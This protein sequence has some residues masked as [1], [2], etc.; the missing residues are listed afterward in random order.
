MP[1]LQLPASVKATFVQRPE[2][3]AQAASIADAVKTL[4]GFSKFIAATGCLVGIGYSLIKRQ[5][6]LLPLVIFFG[7]YVGIHSMRALTRHRYCLPAVWVGLLL[8]IYGWQHICKMVNWK[9]WI[10][11]PVIISLQLI[12]AAAAGIWIAM[13]AGHLAPAARLSPT[14]RY[15][16]YIAA[17]V[18][19]LIFAVRTFIFR[20][21]YVWRDAALSMLACLMV[22]SS[23]F[24]LVRQVGSGKTDLEFKMLADW[25]VKNAEPGEKLAA[26]LTN[27]MRFFAPKESKYFVSTGSIGG[28]D[29][30]KFIQKCYKKDIRYVAWDSRIGL[31]PANSYY[32][33]WG[34][35]KIAMLAR[36]QSTGPYEFITQLKHSDRRY[37]NVF[38]LR[39]PPPDQTQLPSQPQS[40]SGAG[41]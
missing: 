36:P 4:S 22:V 35:A 24:M 19:A 8:C 29:A 16:P 23:Q 2:T 38:R 7:C 27:V 21:R 32:K 17:A 18:I 5:W 30:A 31:T 9:G 6:K 1:L 14:S 20:A 34:I 3:A 37:I 25:Y 41:G 39:K 40:S 11:R 12:V 15:L 10:P 33:K 28:N 26:T 13:L